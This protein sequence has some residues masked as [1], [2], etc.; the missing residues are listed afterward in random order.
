M[1]P[2]WDA[3]QALAVRALKL[4]RLKSSRDILN[5]LLPADHFQTSFFPPIVHN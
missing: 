1:G 3:Y 4:A 2:S 5:L